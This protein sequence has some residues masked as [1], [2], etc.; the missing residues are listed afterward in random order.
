MEYDV[1]P[2]EVPPGKPGEVDPPCGKVEHRFA[3]R[4][5]AADDTVDGVAVGLEP[6]DKRAPDE[7]VR[8]ADEHAH[9]SSSFARRAY[10]DGV[11]D[12]AA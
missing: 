3:L 2:V 8:P 5:V 4:G 7:P 10:R 9:V 6:G 12:F 1:D 11:G